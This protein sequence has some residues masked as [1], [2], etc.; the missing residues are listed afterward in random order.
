MYIPSPFAV[1]EHQALAFLQAHSFGAL[2]THTAGAFHSTPL[3]FLLDLP[4]RSLQFHLAKVNNQIPHLDNA[5]A[6]LSVMGPHHYISPAIYQSTG[7]PTWNYQTVNVYGTTRL[8]TDSNWLETNV[9][10]LTEKYET[11]YQTHWQASFNR[12]MLNAIVGVE[13][14][15]EKIEGKF[16]LGQ[17][18]STEDQINTQQWLHKNGATALAEAMGPQLQQG[19]TKAS[20]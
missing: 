7:V 11:L 20:N 6:M 4:S 1:D 17:N 19:D 2:I 13:M 3:P 16:K 10:Q 5:Q 15:I 12:A 14:Q 8:I 18:R 9:T